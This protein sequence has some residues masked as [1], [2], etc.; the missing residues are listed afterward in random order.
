MGK[1]I[2]KNS[3]VNMTIL[4]VSTDSYS[5]LW[6]AFLNVKNDFGRIVHMRL[7]L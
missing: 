1:S 7:F 4:V 2:D 3:D 6:P 5:D